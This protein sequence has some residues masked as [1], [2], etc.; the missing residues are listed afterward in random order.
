[1]THDQQPHD[2]LP[3]PWTV[4]PYHPL[5]PV[6][7]LDRLLT[8]Q[9]KRELT[10]EKTYV[11]NPRRLRRLFLWDVATFLVVFAL[12]LVEGWTAESSIANAL[13]LP[14]I[15]LLIARTMLA[16]MIRAR[17]YRNGWLDG[18]RHMV[19]SMAEAMQREFTIEEWL[20]GELERDTEVLRYL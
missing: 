5:N 1:M 18:R 9:A 6:G 4:G 12:V 7:W 10:D 2:P 3:D 17:A 20:E 14:I 11:V 13:A 8:A 19:A 16:R 15:I